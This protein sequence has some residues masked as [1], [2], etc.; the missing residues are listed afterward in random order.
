MNNKKRTQLSPF[1]LRFFLAFFILLAMRFMD[2]FIANSPILPLRP[3]S[4]HLAHIRHSSSSKSRHIRH[5]TLSHHPSRADISMPPGIFL[6]RLLG[7]MPICFI[8]LFISPDM[9]PC[10]SCLAWLK[11]LMNLL[12]SI[13]VLPEPA[14]IRRRRLGVSK[15]GFSRSQES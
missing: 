14:A 7:L 11:S 2:C 8:I 3:P 5:T 13:K 10:M 15:S 1:Y 6:G 4:K 12:T 9:T